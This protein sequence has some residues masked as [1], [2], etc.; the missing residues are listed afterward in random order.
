MQYEIS[1]LIK[2]QVDVFYSK[3]DLNEKHRSHFSNKNHGLYKK[4]YL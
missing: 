1:F 3:F 4:S 2:I